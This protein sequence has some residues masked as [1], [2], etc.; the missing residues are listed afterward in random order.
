VRSD[1][2]YELAYSP[3]GA[4]LASTGYLAGPVRLWGVK[5]GR[6]VRLIESRSRERKSVAFSPD[7][8][9]L[10]TA[11]VDGSVR[12]WSV[13]TGAELSW[14]GGRFDRLLGVAFSPDGRMLAARGNDADIRLRDLAEILGAATEP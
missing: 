3:D 1:G 6:L 10:A 13:A 4:L 9:L 5:A 14:V 8:R 11:S 7:G 12:L 2:I